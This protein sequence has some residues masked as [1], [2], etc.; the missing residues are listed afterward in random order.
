M[1]G[2]ELIDV[3]LAWATR[4]RQVLLAVRVAAG[5]TALQAVRQSGILEH[6][7][8]MEPDSLELGIFGHPVRHDQRL[9]AGDRVEIYRPLRLDPR[10]ARRR[11]AARG[12]TIR[13]RPR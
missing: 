7:T 13:A 8:D 12:L 3:E 1:G 6:C 11:L 10:E 9:R 4:E 5:T 2:A